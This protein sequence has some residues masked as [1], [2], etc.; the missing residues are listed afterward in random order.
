MKKKKVIYSMSEEQLSMVEEHAQLRS[1]ADLR[2]I[3]GGEKAVA[4]P[5]ANDADLISLA[6]KGIKLASVE[7]VSE[8]LSISMSKM[9][10]LLHTSQRT[11]QRKKKNDIM[12]PYISEQTIEIAQIVARGIEIF[13]TKE[14]FNNWLGTPLLAFGNQPPLNYLDTTFGTQFILKELGRLQHGVYS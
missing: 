8:H 4:Q 2:I 14:E 3:L 9:S 5:L 6:R 11:F 1:E 12:S 7:S 10:E 13:G